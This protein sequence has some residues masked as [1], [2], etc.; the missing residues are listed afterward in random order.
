MVEEPETQ[1]QETPK[2]AYKR[3]SMAQESLILQLADQGLTQTVIAKQIGCSQPAVSLVLSH[4]EDTR[5]IARKALHN[6]AYEIAEKLIKTKH[7]PTMLEV[8]RDIGVTEKKAPAGESKGGV[9]VFIGGSDIQV[10]VSTF[11]SELTTV[12]SDFHKL[13]EATESDK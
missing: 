13:T 8:L 11:A 10:S 1:E 5:H 6:G 9:Q 12:S 3:L 4:F 2:P 7:A